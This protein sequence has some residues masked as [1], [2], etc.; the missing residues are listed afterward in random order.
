MSPAGERGLMERDTLEPDHGMLFVFDAPA[1]QAFW[2][3]HTRFPLDIIFAGSNGRIVSI[4]TM[5]AYDEE[6]TWSNGPAKYA[7]EIGAG[8]ANAAGVKPG[9]PLQFPQGIKSGRY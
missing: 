2:M 8:E 3:H 7:I 4:S 6:S 1:E 9:D 5:K